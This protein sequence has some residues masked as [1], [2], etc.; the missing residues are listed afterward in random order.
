MN[1]TEDQIAERVFEDGYSIVTD[2]FPKGLCEAYV[3]KFE[4]LLVQR[5]N[6]G[7]GIGNNTSQI[8]RNYFLEIPEAIEFVDN[9]L[10]D[11]VMRKLIDA[12]Y[13]LTSSAATNKQLR[14]EFANNKL[15]GGVGWHTDGRYMRNQ[16]ITPSLTYYAVSILQ[17]FTDQ[18]GA[19]HFVPGS[20]KWTRRVPR[21][22]E[23]K[24]ESFVASAGSIVFFDS[25]LV[26]RTGEA[27][28]LP[29]WG[30]WSLFSPWFIKPYNDFVS[31]YSD[32]EIERLS[33]RQRQLF[34]FSSQPP[35]RGE[36]ANQATLE[37][38]RNKLTALEKAG[39]GRPE[40]L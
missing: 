22:A 30:V 10:I 20:S 25:A 26:H 23:Y 18:N 31:F 39:Q 27:G 36:S 2:V 1:H 15:T 34:H 14:E 17:D 40:I 12:D 28:S 8:L 9:D 32:D 7:L 21:E 5:F 29:R 16:L 24:H 6:K 35:K 19:T 11:Q 38:V 33:P 13:T 4:E 37:R 3:D